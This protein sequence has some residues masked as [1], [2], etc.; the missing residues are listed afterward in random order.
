MKP[1]MKIESGQTNE[2][3]LGET[4]TKE[5]GGEIDDKNTSVEKGHETTT[6]T[7]DNESSSNNNG[8]KKRKANALV[9]EKKTSASTS[10]T[11]KGG[12]KKAKTTTKAKRSRSKGSKGLRHFSM[13]VCKKVEE[14]GITSY[15]EVADELVK[16]FSV[17]PTDGRKTYDEKNIRRRVYDALN[18]LM[19][20]DIIHK[21]KKEIHWKGLPSNAKHDLEALQN[22]RAKLLTS[23]NEKKAHL[24]ELLLQQI[25][26]KN[27]IA[28][29]SQ[30]E[31]APEETKIPLPFIIIN[32]SNQTIIRCEMAEDRGDIF[33]NFSAPF[34]IHDDNEIL[35]RLNLHHAKYEELH[36]LIP[37]QLI[38][39]LPDSHLVKSSEEEGEGAAANAEEAADKGME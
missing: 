4:E 36:K 1:G 16:E 10:E 20:M 25:A 15:N 33:F 2:T 26:F 34:E 23:I 27:L 35:K 37:I 22:Q 13:K 14:K 18:V 21:V 19:A 32:T 28:R 38:P 39:Y 24:Q 3:R 31:E 6:T 5:K 30:C 9:D 7:T 11:V 12:T 17:Q 29:N 8:S